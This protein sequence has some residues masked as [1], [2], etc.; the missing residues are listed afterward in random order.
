MALGLVQKLAW[1]AGLTSPARYVARAQKE[2]PRT[3]PFRNL[4]VDR[5]GHLAARLPYDL[6]VG[7]ADGS[8]VAGEISVVAP[9]AWMEPVW[10]GGHAI[11]IHSGLSEFIY[12]VSRTMH[13]Q[14]RTI[15]GA[16]PDQQIVEPSIPLSQTLDM[17]KRTFDEFIHHRRIEKPGGYPIHEDQIRRAS[18]LAV[19]A[20]AFWLAH[21]LAHVLL[22]RGKASKTSPSEHEEL[23]ADRIAL[24]IVM[25]RYLPADAE[26]PPS[27]RMVYAGA[28]FAIRI[29]SALAHLGFDFKDTHPA[30]DVRLLNLREC[31][32]RSAGYANFT[33]I[34]TIAFAYDTFLEEIERRVVPPDKAGFVIGPTV[35]RLVSVL[36]AAIE[37]CAR[38]RQTEKDLRV[39]VK[40]LRKEAGEPMLLAA[41]AKAEQLY[42]PQAAVPREQDL[43]RMVLEAQAYWQLVEA[44]APEQRRA[45]PVA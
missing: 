20:E 38:G 43:A 31:A 7:L 16:L 22:A 41:F 9:E 37:E 39:V 14:V 5:L 17:I 13:A 6:K 29:Y 32:I 21:E 1:S 42:L 11:L 25:G 33:R 27:G 26:A 2:H 15:S 44:F 10:P 19:E 8:I 28:E 40:A 45:A 18:A 35:E 30:P 23:A 4:A 12:S 3:N 34:S 36:L 24:D